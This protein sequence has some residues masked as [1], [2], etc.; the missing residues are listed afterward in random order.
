MAEKCKYFIQL[1]VAH[2]RVNYF[3][4]ELMSLKKGDK[5]KN[6][7]VAALESQRCIHYP[8]AAFYLGYF[9]ILGRSL[10][11]VIKVCSEHFNKC[12]V[13]TR[14]SGHEMELD[15]NKLQ[16]NM[17]SLNN[18]SSL[19]IHSKAEQQFIGHFVQKH[20]Q[21]RREMVSNFLYIG[22]VFLDLV[23]KLFFN[24]HFQIVV[25]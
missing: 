19:T 11:K 6:I 12:Y 21:D 2:N 3:P 4:Y 24:D 17:C 16:N 18:Q 20:L 9:F 1:K 5:N 23:M 22:K 10:N 8:S 13:L 14:L 25:F 7:S 15:W